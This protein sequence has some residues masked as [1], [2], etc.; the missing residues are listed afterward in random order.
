MDGLGFVSVAQDSAALRWAH[1]ELFGELIDG[2][3]VSRLGIG[4][5]MDVRV[6]VATRGENRIDRID[7]GGSELVTEL[8]R[9]EL[10]YLF[11][12]VR[13]NLEAMI[14]LNRRAINPFVGLFADQL[15]E[16]DGG[17]IGGAPAVDGEVVAEGDVE[18]VGWWPGWRGG[19]DRAVRIIC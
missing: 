8:G 10:N 14:S 3:V 1:V 15:V 18:D 12:L 11:E 5:M 19:V 4:G 17:W 2:D 16:D 6:G 13:F 9:S 7:F